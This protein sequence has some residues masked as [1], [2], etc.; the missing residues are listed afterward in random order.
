MGEAGDGS[1]QSI[2]HD[3]L[4]VRR[5]LC[6]RGSPTFDWRPHDFFVGHRCTHCRRAYAN[7]RPDHLVT[8]PGVPLATYRDSFGNWCTRL[9]APAG[10]FELSTDGV[11]RDGGVPDFQAKYFDIVYGRSTQHDNWLAYI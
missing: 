10:R 2:R 11:F 5:R 4:N 7:E 9:V 6:A 1:D 3:H 8:N